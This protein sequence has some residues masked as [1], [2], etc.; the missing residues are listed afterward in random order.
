MFRRLEMTLALP[1]ILPMLD[2]FKEQ[3]AKL[4]A[5]EQ[6]PENTADVRSFLA[7]FDS[8]FRKNGKISI[9]E[10]KRARILRACSLLRFQ[11]RHDA[12]AAVSDATMETD[13]DPKQYRGEE[14]IFAHCY[15]FLA[16][17]Q[18]HLLKGL[19]VPKR[20]PD[21]G[22][23]LLRKILSR[24]RRFSRPPPPPTP[25]NSWQVIVL[26]D[27]VNL[28]SYVTA[29]LRC[30]LD[31]PEEVAQRRMREVHELKSSIVWEGSQDEAETHVR[32]LQSWHLQAVLRH[33]GD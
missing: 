27:P 31:L 21:S 7:L 17:L 1:L 33:R 9:G 8:R 28:M 6:K 25:G 2:R 26:N 3:A 15:I 14:Q 23:A 12:L 29:V 32:T 13:L 22:L 10:D 11:M 4:E 19:G 20:H 24:M 5:K 18:E 16:A 30:V